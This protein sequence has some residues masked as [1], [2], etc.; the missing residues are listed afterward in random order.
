MGAGINKYVG[1]RNGHPK[2]NFN[3]DF[4]VKIRRET[5]RDED[6][7]SKR[8]DEIISLLETATK[9]STMEIKEFSSIVIMEVFQNV[10]EHG[11]QSFDQ[12]WWVLAQYHPKHKIVSINIADNGIGFKNSLLSGPQGDELKSEKNNFKEGYLIE[13]ALKENISGALDASIKEGKR[14]KKGYKRGAGRGNG[15]NRISSTCE[16]LG[17][18]YNILSHYGY[19]SYNHK[20]NKITHGS[21]E[22]RIFGG[23]LYNF[24]IPGKEL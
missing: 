6:V 3:D 21:R 10:I 13:L 12:G 14:F 22:K 24:N 20:K 8:E 17:I 19:L 15:L 9:Y 7:V 4:I 16:K 11:I 5:Q 1:R 23:T 18:S 2:D